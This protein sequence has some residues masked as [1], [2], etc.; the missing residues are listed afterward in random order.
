[1][2]WCRR[3]REEA[4]DGV[5]SDDAAPDRP[6]HPHV[7]AVGRRVHAHQIRARGLLPRRGRVL[8][9]GDRSRRTPDDSALPG[10]QGARHVAGHTAPALARA[11]ARGA[12]HRSAVHPDLDR[13]AFHTLRP[14]RRAPLL[15]AHVRRVLRPAPRPQRGD[16]PHPGPGAHGRPGRRRARRRRTGCQLARPAPW[17]RGGSWRGGQRCHRQ[18][19][20]SS[21]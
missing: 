19:R 5:M 14:S 3:L 10:R 12:R 6:A 9:G 17:R 20:P 13:R 1:V 21:R 16:K 4:L 7:G 8:P 15:Y 11:R 18:R 2:G